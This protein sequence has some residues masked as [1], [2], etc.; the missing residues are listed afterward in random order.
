VCQH[1]SKGWQPQGS[2][3]AA[4]GLPGIESVDYL[5]WLGPGDS[6]ERSVAW[7][8]VADLARPGFVRAACYPPRRHPGQAAPSS[9]SLLRQ[10]GDEGLAT[11]AA[12][13]QSVSHAIAAGTVAATPNSDAHGAWSSVSNVE[14]KGSPASIRRRHAAVKSAVGPRRM[15][16]LSMLPRHGSQCRYV[17]Q[18]AAAAEANISIAV[19]NH[20]HRCPARSDRTE[21]A[22]LPRAPASA[23][24]S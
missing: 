2:S 18:I 1:H 7:R 23:F 11:T 4:L 12:G 13:K 9:T 19:S 5:G 17:D 10:E 15:E 3:W 24:P 21:L 20:G 16:P 6:Q 14:G 22:E 8:M